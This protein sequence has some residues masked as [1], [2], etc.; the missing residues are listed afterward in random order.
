MIQKKT[1]GLALAACTLLAPLGVAQAEEYPAEIYENYEREPVEGA[2]LGTM[3]IDPQIRS[4]GLYKKVQHYEAMA[5][6]KVAYRQE[7]PELSLADGDG[8][9]MMSAKDLPKLAAALEDYNK[10]IYQEALREQS[11]GREAALRDL[12]ERRESGYAD[13]FGGHS[14]EKDLIVKRA[15]SL[16]L[17]FLE[18]QWTYS[19]GA[20]GGE[21]FRGVNFD[22]ATG[23]RLSLHQVFPDMEQLIVIL[24]EKLYAENNPEMFFDAMEVT[25][26]KQIIQDK[27]SWVLEPRGVT[28][29]FN[30]YEIAPYAS[31][32][33]TTTISFDDRPGMFNPKY[34]L[35]PASYGEELVPYLPNR[36]SLSDDGS[37]KVDTIM[38]SVSADEITII[39][40]DDIVYKKAY[41][42][43][44]KF[45][46]VLVHTRDTQS[47][48]L[49]VD[50]GFASPQM[51]IGRQMDVFRIDPDKIVFMGT[52][53]H[54]FQRSV[55]LSDTGEDWTGRWIMTDPY[56]FNIDD[57]HYS[58]DGKSNTHVVEIGTNGLPT[59]G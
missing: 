57:P 55:D 14:N 42:G 10:S 3:A 59:F 26:A 39:L 49:Y 44:N 8:R 20:H 48:Y 19:G 52:T 43:D 21:T 50:Y 41:V 4:F 34:K 38:T 30:Q 18:K 56:E 12:Q 5:E 17:S 32:T 13:S 7:W 53:A 46:P 51:G 54:S 47:N 23:E 36:V 16:V 45:T 25:V 31:G 9:S 22:A 2:P 15:D 40:N 35:G 6:G 33:I 24:L 29:Y 58:T 11:E 1:L 37:G 28:F 27:A